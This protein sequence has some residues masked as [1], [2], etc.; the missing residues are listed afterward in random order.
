ML[1]VVC[2]VQVL[3]LTVGSTVSLLLRFVHQLTHNVAVIDERFV[4]SRATSF[5]YSC[6]LVQTL[7]KSCDLYRTDL[8][9]HGVQIINHQVN[10]RLV[11]TEG[12]DDC[13]M[14]LLQGLDL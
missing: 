5:P 3:S 6:L 14:R 13:R 1:L 10:Y 12:C 8:F 2:L 7:A 11:Q 9:D 4:L